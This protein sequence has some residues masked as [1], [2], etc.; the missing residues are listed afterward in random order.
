MTT[1]RYLAVQFALLR[2]ASIGGTPEKAMPT[3]RTVS[4]AYHLDV[5]RDAPRASTWPRA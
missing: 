5:V 3:A 2:G 4:L 1:V